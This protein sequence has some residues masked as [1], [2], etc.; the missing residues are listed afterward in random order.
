[1]LLGAFVY[2]AACGHSASQ[3]AH[4]SASEQRRLPTDEYV[5]GAP[6]CPRGDLQRLSADQRAR[7]I[8][9]LRALVRALI[10]HPDALV[11][12]RFVLADSGGG[13]EKE[14]ISVRNL[15]KTFLSASNDDLAPDD[16]CAFDFRRRLEGL[17]G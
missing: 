7:K 16:S 10:S 15:A 5:F 12:A 14:E 2:L 13:P 8:G 3:A 9:E 1:M 6:W 17:I 11:T 4:V